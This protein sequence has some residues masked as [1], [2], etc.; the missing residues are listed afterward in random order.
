MPIKPGVE[1]MRKQTS[2]INHQAEPR[3][4][5]WP[6]K[7]VPKQGGQEGYKERGH[8]LGADRERGSRR[9]DSREQSR[10]EAGR[11]AQ[12]PPRAR[13]LCGTER[14]LLCVAAVLA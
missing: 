8:E 9:E 13:G 5:W 3:G 6:D 10:Q 2:I 14:G 1:E 11:K 7:H 12:E 4:R